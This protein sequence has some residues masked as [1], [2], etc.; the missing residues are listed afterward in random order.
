MKKGRVLLRVLLAIFISGLSLA[1]LASCTSAPSR[2]SSFYNAG[3]GDF[4]PTGTAFSQL[5]LYRFDTTAAGRSLTL[6]SAADIVAAVPS[7]VVGDVLVF[8]VTAEGDNAVTI[9]GGAN[10]TVAAS[11]ITVRGH[12][13]LTVFC[14]LDNIS[15]GSQAVSIY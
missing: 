1:T 2:G 13:T 8:G 4:T 6:P 12:S 5:F 7:A 14:V 10:V 3:A 11:A 9:I 15:A